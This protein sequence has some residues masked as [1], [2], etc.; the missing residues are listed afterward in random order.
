MSD[1]MNKKFLKLRHGESG[2]SIIQAVFTTVVVAGVGAAVFVATG[3][4]AKNVES[5]KHKNEA[6]ALANQVTLNAQPILTNVGTERNEGLCSF[7]RTQHRTGGTGN[8]ELAIPPQTTT[9]LDSRWLSAF[10]ADKWDVYD[11]NTCL[12]EREALLKEDPSAK[13]KACSECTNNAYRRCLVAKVSAPIPGVSE[14]LLK[15]RPLVK[16]ELIPVF[17]R[18]TFKEAFNPVVLNASTN[19]IVNARDA[20]FLFSVAVEGQDNFTNTTALWSGLFTCK[21]R[22][23]GRDLFLNPSGIG[24]GIQANTV[25][26]STELN[27]DEASNALSVSFTRYHDT[28]FVTD[29]AGRFVS[30]HDPNSSYSAPCM[31]K[32]FT[33]KNRPASARVWKKDID[34]AARIKLVPTS[35]FPFTTIPASP[36]LLVRSE[37]DSI[38]PQTKY[39]MNG[40]EYLGMTD[41]KT[42]Y[43]MSYATLSMNMTDSGTEV[44]PRVCTDG[45]AGYRF[46]RITDPSV[47]SA[48]SK[49]YKLALQ[50]KVTNK[51]KIVKTLLAVDDIEVFCQCCSQKACGTRALHEM[52]PCNEQPTEALDARIPECEGTDNAVAA[53]DEPYGGMDK[54][55][56]ER[57]SCLAAQVK[58]NG[59]IRLET[60][61]CGNNLPGVCFFQGEF[62]VGRSFP[63]KTTRTGT[64]A[65]M[66]NICYEMGK[67]RLLKGDATLGTGVDGLIARQDQTVNP[68]V[69]PPVESVDGKAY[70]SLTNAGIV[71]LFLGPQT[72]DQWSSA[73]T[74][75]QKAKQ[76]N[77][78]Q[79]WFW[80]G[81]RTDE[82]KRIYAVAPELD[83]GA[84]GLSPYLYFYDTIPE[85][86][87]SQK[88]NFV[89]DGDHPFGTGQKMALLHSR[90]FV[91][92]FAVADGGT[93]PELPV[94]C[95]NPTS[96]QFF[97]S[98]AI[99]RDHEQGTQICR[100]EA[101]V[102]VAP[103]TPAQW[104]KALL[105][106][107]PNA[108][109]L[110]WPSDPGFPA[111]WA[112][113]EK[114]ANE[115]QPHAMYPVNTAFLDANGEIVAD[116][117]AP[118]HTHDLCVRESDN[119]LVLRAAPDSCLAGETKYGKITAAN[120]SRVKD[121][122]LRVFLAKSKLSGELPSSAIVRLDIP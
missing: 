87:N 61:D 13:P 92:A 20:G 119:T 89:K 99:T 76:E 86:R 77:P 23:D 85:K 75:M 9:T 70:Y 97:K 10:P 68:L 58:S 37:T 51:D 107:A 66:R 82:D 19:T 116:S 56:F 60:R 114:K 64:F 52:L 98:S 6:A 27:K 103:M 90:R 39:T 84:A 105:L 81:L 93:Q 111:A 35:E 115:W 121:R 34:I 113:G 47:A 73:K 12:A 96:N 36:K 3:R 55:D 11:R 15:L 100:N 71:G 95:L 32:F 38:A 59:D 94:L 101:G 122:Q 69:M 72:L 17:M 44:C 33:C 42:V 31:E 112:A 1:F 63:A 18:N 28:T 16:A 104:V 5:G 91:G 2:M 49:I 48:A 46:N 74:S 50:N 79:E 24:S 7:V 117:P 106:V 22:V 110:A 4:V 120:R 54:G 29:E 41:P 65:A 88:I 43:T 118:M 108:S 109:T 67:E 62:V 78:S 45:G 21:V 53:M 30:N 8:I 26:S 14:K 57:D 83:G 80:V 102:F 40:L 25:F